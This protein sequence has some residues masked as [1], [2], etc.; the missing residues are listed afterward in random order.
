MDSVTEILY[1]FVNSLCPFCCASEAFVQALP[2]TTPR[3]PSGIRP[4]P[5]TRTSRVGRSPAPAGS[6]RL[7]PE[8]QVK[9]SA[10]KPVS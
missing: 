7:P 10:E 4:D 6:S 3:A 5:R 2:A 8:R 9:A 1:P